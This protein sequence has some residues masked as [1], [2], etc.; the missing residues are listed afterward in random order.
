LYRV[1]CVSRFLCKSLI[2]IETATAFLN[3][4][5]VIRGTVRLYWWYAYCR[6]AVWGVSWLYSGFYITMT[7][8]FQQRYSWNTQWVSMWFL[9]LLWVQQW[10]TAGSSETFLGYT[11]DSV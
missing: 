3:Y 4:W 5:S 9:V 2:C 6:E 11:E 10:S 1:A 7:C 8:G